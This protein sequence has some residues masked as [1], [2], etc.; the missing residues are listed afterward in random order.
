M[1]TESP[2]PSPSRQ[3]ARAL[4]LLGLLVLTLALVG[5]VV[6]MGGRVE[7]ATWGLVVAAAALV[8][9]LHALYRM[10]TVLSR[11]AVEVVIDQDDLGALA[12][13]RELREE[14]RRVL[15]AINELQFDYEMGKLSQE[16]YEKVRQGYQLRAV[17]VM[18]ALDDRPALHPAL[19]A[20]LQ[21][22]GVRPGAGSKGAGSKGEES[23][24]V[25]GSD[26]AAQVSAGADADADAD[27]DDA[28][29][30]SGRADE[31]SDATARDE[32]SDEDAAVRASAG[33]DADDA[34]RA[35]AG[36]DEGASAGDD[37]G[38]ESSDDDWGDA[39]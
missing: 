10:A 25:S 29:R 18:R 23:K 9:T 14:R 21:R 27:A 32:D 33:A 2:R 28:A 31:D 36:D 30:A 39:R 16:D 17:E 22:R 24:G 15:R 12:G 11:P 20:E 4:W 37:V 6:M 38:D 1:S 7:A 13:V 19:E 34:A 8:F 5:T 26:A 3:R 35:S